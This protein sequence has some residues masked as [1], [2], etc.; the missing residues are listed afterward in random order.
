MQTAKDHVP[1]EEVLTAAGIS[2]ADFPV[3]G[4]SGHHDGAAPD[5]EANRTSIVVPPTFRLLEPGERRRQNE[6]MHTAL[7]VQTVHTR[8]Q[9]HTSASDIIERGYWGGEI[10]MSRDEEDEWMAERQRKI[11]LLQERKNAR[12]DGRPLTGMLTL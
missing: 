6:S 1:I 4:G 2:M 12:R 7:G 11:E 8:R 3:S 9:P 5:F 10:M